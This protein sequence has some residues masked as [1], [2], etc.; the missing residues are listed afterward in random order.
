MNP[1]VLFAFSVALLAD[2]SLNAAEKPRSKETT[3]AAVRLQIFLDRA[4]FAPGKIDGRYGEFTLKALALYRQSRGETA[5]AAPTPEKP[6]KKKGKEAAAPAPDVSGLDLA[7]ISPVFLSYAVTAEDLKAVGEVADTIAGQAKQKSLPYKTA[8]EAIAEKFHTDIDFLIELNRGKTGKIKAG[9]VLTVPNVEP[10]ELIAVKDLK[11]GS[12]IAANE[13][14]EAEDSATTKKPKDKTDKEEKPAGGAAPSGVSV[15]VDVK[16]NMLS[17]FD[18]AK[19][20]AAYPVTIGSDRTESPTGDWKV[21]GVAKM[22]NFRYDKAMLNKGER[23]GD[24][25][26]LPPGPNNPVGIVW[27]Q[28]NKKGIGL[29]GTNDPDAIGRNASHGCIRLANWDV[30]RLASKVK[31]GVPVSIR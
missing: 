18:G 14:E 19:L 11:P 29:H 24:F 27:I 26:M 9:D 2:V 7:S 21:R 28:L 3:E 30:V 8:A 6:A 31:A 22:P 10:F 13:A 17:V 4:E 20:I 16:T 15:Q 12:E 5:P 23:S 25:K 1:R